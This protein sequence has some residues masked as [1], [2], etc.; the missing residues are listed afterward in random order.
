VKAYLLIYE[1]KTIYEKRKYTHHDVFNSYEEAYE[2]GKKEVLYHITHEYNDSRIAQNEYKDDMAG[3]VKKHIDYRFDIYAYQLKSESSENY[4][5]KEDE[6]SKDK[7]CCFCGVIIGQEEHRFIRD[8]TCYK[9]EW[10]FDAFGNLIDRIY[11]Q[12]RCHCYT[13]MPC[14]EAEDAGTKFNVGD[15]V[16]IDGDETV[17]YSIYNTT[18]GVLKPFDKAVNY[19]PLT[20]Y[21]IYGGGGKKSDEDRCINIWENT[22]TLFNVDGFAGH[23]HIHESKIKLFSGEVPKES[24]LW[25][26]REYSLGKNDGSAIVNIDGEEMTLMDV[27]NDDRISLHGGISWRE[28]LKRKKGLC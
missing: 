27:F 18:E 1:V 4:V 6:D 9:I 15:F 14:D 25:F 24:P 21:V 19:D 3:F 7:R 10:S 5:N 28:I 13:Y 12:D 20:V 16:F 11:Y 8:E 17:N 26:W 22:Y 2:C 23:R